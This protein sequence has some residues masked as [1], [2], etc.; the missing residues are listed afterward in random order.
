MEKRK[1]MSP[2]I[3][4]VVLIAATM[5]IAA[6]I[7]FWASGFVKEKLTESES[8]TGGSKCFGAEF[9]LRSGSYDSSTKS[10]H[11][12]LDNRK[13]VDLQIKNVFLI[14]SD[15][16]VATKTLDNTTLKGNEIKDFTIEN[17]DDGFLTGEIKTQ[18]PDVSIYFTYSQ[19]T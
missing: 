15:E 19:V 18:C 9:N 1:G 12:I 11:L 6:V 4:A 17:V 5:T 14:Y 2:L 7:A 8:I 16:P 3:A 10:L 13:S